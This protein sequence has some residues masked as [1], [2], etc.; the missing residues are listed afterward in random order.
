MCSSTS[1]LSCPLLYLSSNLA[2]L[3]DKSYIYIYH[4]DEEC[5]SKDIHSLYLFKNYTIVQIAQVK[6][7]KI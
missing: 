6:K 2:P 5:V 7:L 3:D 1:Q 4:A